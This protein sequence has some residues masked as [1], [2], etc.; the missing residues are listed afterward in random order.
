MRRLL[1]S[2][3]FLSFASPVFAAASR[4]RTIDEIPSARES[5]LRGVSP[6]FYKTLLISP[7]S[8][9]VAVRGELAGT[10]LVGTRVIH[11]ELD[12]RYDALALELANNI[13]IIGNS[14]F[15]S[16]HSR[17]VLV[18]V[19]IYDIADGRLA[20][21]FANLE[22]TGGSQWRYYGAAWMS[23]E[24]R[25]HLW[26]TI[27]PLTLAPHELRGA[28]MYTVQVEAPG[29][30]RVPLPRAVGNKFLPGTP[31]NLPK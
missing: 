5:L 22:D 3:L 15:G 4:G 10:G 1:L 9:W 7:V 8:G 2:L 29:P 20:V 14:N 17:G 13:Q 30:A 19:L 28:R 26:V 25:N 31:Q 6:R 12:G 27:N 16:L 23:V 21:S 11:S 24:K 18:H